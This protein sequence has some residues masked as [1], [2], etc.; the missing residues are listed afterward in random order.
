[1]CWVTLRKGHGMTNIE[2]PYSGEVW[3]ISY[4][5][6]SSFIKESEKRDRWI[7]FIQLR[8]L[9]ILW[10]LHHELSKLQFSH[11]LLEQAMFSKDDRSLLHINIHKS[12]P[13]SMSQE[14]NRKDSLWL[15]DVH[16]INYS[17]AWFRH[18]LTADLVDGHFNTSVHNTA[19]QSF[20]EV[21]NLIS[22]QLNLFHLLCKEI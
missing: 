11:R 19:I 12:R 4:I 14:Y 10:E 5:C 20:Y 18:S 13:T 15:H 6:I 7:C 2:R 1:M 16:N 3:K 17:W 22:L 9:H 21:L 8:Y